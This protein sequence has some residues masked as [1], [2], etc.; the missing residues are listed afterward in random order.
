MTAPLQVDLIQLR[1][2]ADDAEAV[3]DALT[4]LSGRCRELTTSGT[5]TFGEQQTAA[6]Y[7]RFRQRW[8]DDSAVIAG[9]A[10][11]FADGLAGSVTSYTR[12]DS[13]AATRIDAAAAH[14]SPTLG[15]AR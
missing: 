1:K 6:A 4:G 12:S 11:E 7:A 13:S 5:G 8:I 3:A 2:L 14:R 9:G 10:A 15:R